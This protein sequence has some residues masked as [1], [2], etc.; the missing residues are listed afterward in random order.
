MM[1]FNINAEYT[2]AVRAGLDHRA[3]LS[4]AIKEATKQYRELEAQN[5]KLVEALREIESEVI[6]GLNSHKVHHEGCLEDIFSLVKEA[7]KK[8][9]QE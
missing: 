1:G 9:E 3:A 8:G 2:D 4:V 7:L 5:A 6:T